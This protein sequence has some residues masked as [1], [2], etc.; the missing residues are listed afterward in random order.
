MSYA[1]A[2]RNSPSVNDWMQTNE[3]NLRNYVTDTKKRRILEP[4]D[5][6]GQKINLA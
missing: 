6:N 4:E 2:L 1:Y 5:W 3:L